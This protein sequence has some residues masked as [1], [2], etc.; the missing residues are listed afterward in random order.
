[1]SS[2]HFGNRA[3]TSFQ[4]LLT[5]TA[6]AT[7]GTVV[8]DTVD[9]G[10]RRCDVSLDNASELV[11][12]CQ[13]I[14][15][16]SNDTL[17]FAN[18]RVLVLVL[19]DGVGVVIGVVSAVNTQLSEKPVEEAEP[20]VER[21]AVIGSTDRIIEH[22]G[23]KIIFTADGDVVIQ[24]KRAL[25]AEGSI[26]RIEGA[27]DASDNPVTLI[28][29]TAWARKVEAMLQRHEA[30]IM[31]NSPFLKVGVAGPEPVAPPTF[32]AEMPDATTEGLGATAIKIPT[33]DS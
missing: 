28:P 13:V 23:S 16:A 3:T 21:R 33:G 30:W 11:R 9:R 18:R 14:R 26:V 25:R 10:V 8:A 29:M 17:S 27:G 5:N 7:F 1:M 6:V 19:G 12:G 32:V 4:R 22:A 2:R 20:D 31:S 15:S 24:P